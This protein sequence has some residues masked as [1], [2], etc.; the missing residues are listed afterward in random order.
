MNLNTSYAKSKQGESSSMRMPKVKPIG[1]GVHLVK[2][3]GRSSRSDG[4]RD[5]DEATA[6]GKPAPTCAGPCAS[7]A[8]NGS[9]VRRAPA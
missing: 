3:V 4:N 5:S 1:A 8:S 2:K 6:K 7:S 9:M